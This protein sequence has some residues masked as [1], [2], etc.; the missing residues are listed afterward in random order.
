MHFI[1]STFLIHAKKRDV[2]ISSPFSVGGG[3]KMKAK[4]KE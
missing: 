1:F 4:N 3:Q 2:I